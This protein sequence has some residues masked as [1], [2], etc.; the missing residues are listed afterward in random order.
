MESSDDGEGKIVERRQLGP[1]QVHQTSC[2]MHDSSPTCSSC[3]GNYRH[4]FFT[5][6]LH[7]TSNLHNLTDLQ[8]ETLHHHFSRSQ[9]STKQN[10]QTPPS[11]G[12]T[13]LRLRPL[14]SCSWLSKT[15]LIFVTTTNPS[16]ITRPHTSPQPQSTPPPQVLFQPIVIVIVRDHLHPTGSLQLASFTNK[17]SST[18]VRLRAAWSFCLVPPHHTRLATQQ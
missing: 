6:S 10:L 7:V 18:V 3:R 9:P 2:T 12:I 1:S 14:K 13:M 15:N 8:S 5:H 11:R 4:V 17:D 16:H